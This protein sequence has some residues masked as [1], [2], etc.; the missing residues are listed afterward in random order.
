MAIEIEL[1][2]NLLPGAERRQVLSVER[3]M[4]VRD[5]AIRL[6]VRPQDIGLIVVNGV[7]SELEDRVPDNARV[8]FFPPMSG[9]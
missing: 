2:G 4:T 7:Q 5:V 6:G 9:G 1:G 3:E 8:C